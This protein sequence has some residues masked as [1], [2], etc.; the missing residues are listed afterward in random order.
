M[1]AILLLSLLACDKDGAEDTAGDTGGDAVVVDCDALSFDFPL[2]R[3]E[4]SGAWDAARRRFVFFGGNLGV[5]EEC[6]ETTADFLDDTWAFYPDCG[7]F[8][9]LDASGPSA[10]GRHV[11]AVD[12]DRGWMILHGGRYRDDDGGGHGGSSDY[13]LYDDVWALDLATDT[14]TQLSAGGGPEARVSHAAAVRGGKLFIHGGN[15]STSGLS[16]IAHGDLW[17]FD[18][19]SRTWTEISAPGG[20]EDRLFHGGAL[21]SDGFFYVY[22]G[23]DE[24]AFTGPFLDDLWALDMSSLSWTELHGGGA[25]APDGR[26]SPSVVVDE[27]RGR[28][29]VFGGH[30]DGALGNNNQ[31]WAFDLDSGSWTQLREGDVYA[32]S[33]AVCNLP[34][35]FTDPDFDSPERRYT[36]ASALTD[37]GQMIVFGG[38]TDCGV[39]DDIWAFDLASDTW[40]EWAGATT[41]EVCLRAYA[42]CEGLCF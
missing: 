37:D 35:D 4:L 8:V 30:D 41:G 11:I 25:D 24:R 23:G 40:T 38:K 13:T 15:S 1:S 29:V 32:N 31:V 42:E 21:S 2:A 27:E 17:S 18:L 36:Q 20:P 6:S 26:L 10:R 28:L 14:W 9:K 39:V 33:G 7:G 12:E 3:G 34:S 16:Y 5:P 19:E 22:G